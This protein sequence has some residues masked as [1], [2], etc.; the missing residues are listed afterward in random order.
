M[1]YFFHVRNIYGST[2]INL[3]LQY[4]RKRC[5][6]CLFSP[7]PLYSALRNRYIFLVCHRAPTSSVPV[8]PFRKLVRTRESCGTSNEADC[9]PTRFFAVFQLSNYSHTDLK[10]TCSSHRNTTLQ[11]KTI[12]RRT[13]PHPASGKPHVD[14]VPKLYIHIMQLFGIAPVFG[15]FLLT[16]QSKKSYDERNFGGRMLIDSADVRTRSTDNNQILPVRHLLQSPSSSELAAQ[17]S[18]VE[19]IDVSTTASIDTP[20]SNN[21]NNNKYVRLLDWLSTHHD[22]TISDKIVVQPS[23]S[24][25]GYGAFVTEAVAA[26]E[27]LFTV[28][29]SA[30]VTLDRALQDVLLGEGLQALVAAAGPGGNTVALAGY[31]AKE[32]VAQN[33]KQQQEASDET[34]AS[35]TLTAT[36]YGP[37]LDTLPWARGLNNQ[38]HILFWADEEIESKLKGSQCYGEALDLRQEVNLAIRVLE[39]IIGKAETLNAVDTFLF[40]WQK[41]QQPQL[42]VEG[43]PQAVKGAFVCLLTRAFQ[44]GDGDEEKLVPLLDMLQHSDDPNVSHVMRRDDGTVEVRA[45]QALQAGDELMNQYRSEMEE[46]MP[47]H[48][49]F[50]RFG[51]VPGVQEPIDN[52]LADKSSIFFPQK[53]E[54]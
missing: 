20:T 42:P 34:A 1:L 25:N 33:K 52:L 51:F 17:A 45:R 5:P 23:A 13:E 8:P 9:E 15:L 14:I 24:G 35:V 41:K 39:S 26:D 40:P 43:L 44:D 22:A 7:S 36:S 37:Y 3:N 49:F 47:Y 29:R 50:T 4:K 18:A 16:R 31:L 6:K 30:C 38:E 10:P 28:P 12:H 53:A 21:D 32:R 11:S 46:N 48:R 54:V 2:G 27:L 19:E